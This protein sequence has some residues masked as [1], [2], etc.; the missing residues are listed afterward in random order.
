MTST[1][2]LSLKSIVKQAE[3]FVYMDTDTLTIQDPMYNYYHDYHRRTILLF[4]V[5]PQI[6]SYSVEEFLAI[7]DDASAHGMEVHYIGGKLYYSYMI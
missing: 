1:K 3:Q 5:D 2:T 4:P 6:Y 7:C